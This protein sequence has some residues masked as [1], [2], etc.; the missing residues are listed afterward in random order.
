[1]KITRRIVHIEIYAVPSTLP[2]ISREAWNLV[3]V[4]G[5]GAADEELL[6]RLSKSV[7]FRN[8]PRKCP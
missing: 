5:L 1:M 4:I 2:L 3:R 8:L 6:V 7:V